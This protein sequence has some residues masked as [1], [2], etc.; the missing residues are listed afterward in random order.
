MYVLKYTWLQRFT[1]I[2]VSWSVFYLGAWRSSRDVGNSHF[3]I[4]RILM[5]SP[6]IRFKSLASQ[7]V[8]AS[9]Q[10]DHFHWP[11]TAST[12]AD[13]WQETESV[14][15]RLYITISLVWWDFF[16]TCY[17]FQNNTLSVQM[18]AFFCLA[19]FLVSHSR[20]HWERHMY[21]R[22]FIIAAR[23]Q[24]VLDPYLIDWSRIW[25]I[26][27]FPLPK[28]IDMTNTH[29]KWLLCDA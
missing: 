8:R 11:N 3:L 21:F 13:V 29:R 9:W 4:F 20:S 12:A 17:S 25:S 5:K 27:F 23:L 26:A 14:L 6:A 2:L 16:F 15:T 18:Y 7:L 1:E 24:L 28:V 22:V 10:T 19:I